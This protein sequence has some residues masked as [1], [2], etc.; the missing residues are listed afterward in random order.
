MKQF[1][2]KKCLQL[3]SILYPQK[4]QPFSACL[5]IVL[6]KLKTLIILL[7]LYVKTVAIYS[8]FNFFQ[9]LKKCLHLPNQKKT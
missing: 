9:I 8:C 3:N 6:I 5:Y 2:Q 4:T 7:T 1:S